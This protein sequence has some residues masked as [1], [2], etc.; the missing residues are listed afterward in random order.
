[1]TRRPTLY[2]THLDLKIS[3]PELWVRTISGLTPIPQII[4]NLI[5]I[6]SWIVVVN[7]AFG[8]KN[9]LQVP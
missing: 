9:R 1:M 4:E 8:T 5:A 6:Y 7:Y 2:Q 3:V